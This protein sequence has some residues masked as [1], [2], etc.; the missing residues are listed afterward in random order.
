MKQLTSSANI[1]SINTVKVHCNLISTN[2]ED[3]KRNTHILYDFPL[4]IDNIGGKVI[5]TPNPICYFPV[6]TSVIYELVIR[7]TDQSDKLIDLNSEEINITL[8]FRSCL[9]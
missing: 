8:D 3:L 1:F 7:I 2:I 5:K 9:R 4:N 6:N